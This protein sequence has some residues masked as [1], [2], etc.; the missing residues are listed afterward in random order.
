[1][2]TTDDL[3]TTWVNEVREELSTLGV[4]LAPVEGSETRLCATHRSWVKF[5]L[6]KCSGGVNPHATFR[7]IQEQIA[8]DACIFSIRSEATTSPPSVRWF[9]SSLKRIANRENSWT[10]DDWR[11]VRVWMIAGVQSV[12]G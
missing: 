6:E 3:L 5:E 9:C 8:D 11:E 12:I 4:H 2:I 7:I 10:S 1:M